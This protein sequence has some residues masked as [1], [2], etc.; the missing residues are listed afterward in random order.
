MQVSLTIFGHI[1]PL[2][3]DRTSAIGKSGVTLALV[4]VSMVYV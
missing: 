3:V 1:W 4:S 2:S